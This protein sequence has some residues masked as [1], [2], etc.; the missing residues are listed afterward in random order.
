MSVTSPSDKTSV[1]DYVIVSAE[2]LSYIVN[3]RIL[4]LDQ[5]F[6]YSYTLLMT[7]L[8]FQNM[9]GNQNKTNNIKTH[10]NNYLNKRTQWKENRITDFKQ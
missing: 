9:C 1:I 8:R 2:T 5:L 10:N 6:T 4:E 7:K 3:F